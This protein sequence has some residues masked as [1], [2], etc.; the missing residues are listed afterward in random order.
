[1]K[2]PLEDHLPYAAPALTILAL[3][4]G[5]YFAKMLAQKQ[6]GMRATGDMT[7]FLLQ[8]RMKRQNI[9]ADKFQFV[10]LANSFPALQINAL[11]AACCGRPF[12]FS[13][14]YPPSR[15]CMPDTP[16]C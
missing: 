2:L 12:R 5:T 1:M 9:Y 6:R 7:C 3:F 11:Q 14:R 4:Y 8:P 10:E 16:S 15:H 13:R